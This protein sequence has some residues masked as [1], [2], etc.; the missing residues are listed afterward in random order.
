MFFLCV[1]FGFFVYPYIQ[2]LLLGEEVT[3]PARLPMYLSFLSNFDILAGHKPAGPPLG[4]LW[5]I[6][7]EEQFY[8]IWPIVLIVFKKF[9]ATTFI[10]ILCI[11]WLFRLAYYDHEP[12][13]Y[14]HTFSIISDMTVG[15]MLGWMCFRSEQFKARIQALKRQQIVGIYLLGFALIIF[16]D[17]WTSLGMIRSLERLVYSA[18]FGFIILEQIYARESWFKVG[19]VGFFSKWGKYTYGLYCLHILAIIFTDHVFT[20]FEINNYAL[21]ILIFKPAVSFLVAM[22]ISWVSYHFFEKYFLRLKQRLRWDFFRRTT[23]DSDKSD[24]SV[25]AVQSKAKF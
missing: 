10:V 13:L 12:V 1:G 2:G 25:E 14:L 17:A 22:L 18:F 20:L 19:T 6:S 15:G 3:E 16:R 8:L 21:S 9:R 11:S 7:V 24:I 5:S 4:V 23:Q